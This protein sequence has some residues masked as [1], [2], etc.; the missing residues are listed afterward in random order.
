MN[1]NKNKL[2]D[3][4]NTIS[5][6][7]KLNFIL[8]YKD[9][10]EITRLNNIELP[11]TIKNNELKMIK[12]IVENLSTNSKNTVC[13]FESKINLRYI[14][15]NVYS[16]ENYEG[17]IFIGPYINNPMQSNNNEDEY[18]DRLYKIIPVIPILQEKAIE[19]IVT[20][21][22]N[23]K[24]CNYKNIIIKES[25]KESIK[26]EEYYL[27]EFDMGRI[28]IRE[29][30]KIENKLLHF[31]SQGNK[32]NALEMI[33]NK[34]I[35][36]ID[37]FP[38]EPIRNLKNFS[39]TVN[40]LLRKAVEENN[41]DPYL[42]DSISEHFAKKIEKSNKIDLINNIFEEMINEYCNLVNEYKTKGYSKL[43]SDTINYIKLSF[44]YEI[45]L[46]IIAD[47]LF[48]HPTH[49]S[50]KFKEETGKT[51]SEYIN[52]IRVKEAKMM[53]K[54]T[55]FKI[56]DI[57]YYVGYNDKKYFSKVFKKIY[58]QSPSDYRKYN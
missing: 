6:I 51:V 34:M 32:K 9:K 28:D 40:T 18:I 27:K 22:L 49:L 33:N 19:N 2:K 13:Y 52:E 54:T 50:K 10:N 38:E 5:S 14:I 21:M 29:R 16:H 43:V 53:L 58:N 31:V 23:S 42:L 35:A 46:S 12:S 41:I 36:T 11:Q 20:S 56:E 30:Y 57:A 25:N 7:F 44:K 8:T 4:Y 3:I 37:R 24:I 45:S 48:V 55:E 17:S 26:N 15:F 39:I 47:E 1:L